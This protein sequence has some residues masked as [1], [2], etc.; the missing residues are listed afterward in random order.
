MRVR[1]PED[2]GNADLVEIT[3]EG[4]INLKLR[5]DPSGHRQWFY[6]ELLQVKNRRIVV[7]ILNAGEASWPLG[8]EGFSAAVQDGGWPWARAERTSYRDGVLRIEHTATTDRIAL[9]TFAAYPITRHQALIAC[10]VASPR[11]RREVLGRTP[12]GRPIELLRL[13]RE[14]AEAPR[15]WIFARQHPGEVMAE[16]FM[17][18]LLARLADPEDEPVNRLLTQAALRLVPNMNPDGSARGHHR[19]N[20]RGVD[21]NRAW[22][23][24]IDAPEVELV[25]GRMD[26]E[27]VAIALDVHGDEEVPYTYLISGQ[28]ALRFDD[29]LQAEFN[30]FRAAWHQL[31]P[32]MSLK[33]GAP[34]VAPGEGHLGVSTKQLVTRFGA[35]AATVEM[36]YRSPSGEEFGPSHAKGLG[37]SCVDAVLAA[38]AAGRGGE[39]AP[40]AG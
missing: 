15:V 22:A 17:E 19:V 10:A 38:L 3:P 23:E 16:W 40:K 2:S 32:L 1:T 12:D 14:D 33:E 39:A 29:A 7:N 11:V 31:D 4:E 18:G 25:R 34:P 26:K 24:P 36:P 21:L 30:A 28:G 5:P 9:A 13:G 35:L 27:G 6:V 8:W 20:A 37:E